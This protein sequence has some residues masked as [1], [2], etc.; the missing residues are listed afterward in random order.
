MRGLNRAS[1]TFANRMD[2]PVKPGG[3]IGKCE[4]AK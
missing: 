3:D 2:R 1:M 4:R